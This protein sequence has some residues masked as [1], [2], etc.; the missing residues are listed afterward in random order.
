MSRRDNSFASVSVAWQFK[1]EAFGPGVVEH[2]KG[3]AFTDRALA[4][5]CVETANGI[6]LSCRI[7]KRGIDK[8]NSFHRRTI[9]FL[10]KDCKRLGAA[11]GCAIPPQVSVSRGKKRQA[12]SYGVFHCTTSDG[13][14]EKGQQ[15][16]R[17][18]ELRLKGER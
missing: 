8:V 18:P 9:A 1:V 14:K 6:N 7:A 17:N 2:L 11:K 12:T 5:F 15:Q 10:A 4:L 3:F 13:D 16:A